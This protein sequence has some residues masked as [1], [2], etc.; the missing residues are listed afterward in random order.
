M[1]AARSGTGD[2]PGSAGEVGARLSQ[3]A[4]GALQ[5][6]L[7][8]LQ[9]LVGSDPSAVEPD[10][11]Q[12]DAVSVLVDLGM[13]V[14]DLMKAD[15]PDPCGRSLRPVAH[16]APTDMVG[17]AG[18]LSIWSDG[19]T[20]WNIQLLGSPA[21]VDVR[22]LIAVASRASRTTNARR[23]TVAPRRLESTTGPGSALDRSRVLRYRSA[24]VGH[25]ARLSPQ[26]PAFRQSLLVSALRVSLCTQTEEATDANRNRQVV[27]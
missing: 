26:C 16:R 10:A 20:V 17:T 8:L 13:Q 9:P 7:K 21:R 25:P 1:T 4:P 11:Q 19:E 22:R 12:R 23:S 27:Q 15:L 3:S 14:I 6:G 24:Q 18:A 2:A 5:P